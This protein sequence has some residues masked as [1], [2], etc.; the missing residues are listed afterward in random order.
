MGAFAQNN[1]WAFVG[2]DAMSAMMLSTP[3]TW[4]VVSRPA[5]LANSMIAS[6]RSRQPA[7]GD[8]DLDAILSI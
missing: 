7:V 1:F 6:P 2:R 3:G 5:W 8:L 4:I